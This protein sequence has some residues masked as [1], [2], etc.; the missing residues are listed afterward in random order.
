LLKQSIICL[1]TSKYD[2]PS[3]EFYKLSVEKYFFIVGG[4]R[5]KKVAPG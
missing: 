5:G 2:T 1:G 4:L 3:S